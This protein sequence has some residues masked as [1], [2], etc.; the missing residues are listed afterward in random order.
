MPA[1]YSTL[2][3][4]DTAKQPRGCGDQQSWDVRGDLQRGW[5]AQSGYQVTALP[6]LGGANPSSSSI[7][8]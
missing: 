2:H 1:C 6:L 5:A 3:D 4:I 7:P 8:P